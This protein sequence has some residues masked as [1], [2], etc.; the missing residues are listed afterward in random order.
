MQ[1]KYGDK[2]F[3]ILS[4][5]AEDRE[6]VE[7]FQKTRKEPIEYTVGLRSETSKAYGVRG[8]P[9]A[10]LIGTDGKLL[11]NGHPSSPQC[12]E[13]IAKAL[14]VPI[15][16]SLVRNNQPE[17]KPGKVTDVGKTLESAAK[18][19]AIHEALLKKIEQCRQEI[20]S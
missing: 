16:A 17:V 15:P 9:A 19:K 11:W 14:G 7:A 20:V 2:G 6:T 13:A 12:E 5:T 10:F 3:R 18:K 4:L 1:K 8:I